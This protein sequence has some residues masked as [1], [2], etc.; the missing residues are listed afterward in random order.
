MLTRARITYLVRKDPFGSST[1]PFSLPTIKNKQHH[2]V[3]ALYPHTTQNITLSH[4]LY[5]STLLR[6]SSF[7]TAV[8]RI[9]H[10]LTTGYTLLIGVQ[11]EWR[12]HLFLSLSLSKRAKHRSRRS[13]RTENAF[14]WQHSMN[15]G[16]GDCCV[17]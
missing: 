10:V 6:H 4:Q 12:Y 11:Q 13:F 1:L 16:R 3:T 9:F 2:H 14:Y 8:S 7:R 17:E 5:N 15:V